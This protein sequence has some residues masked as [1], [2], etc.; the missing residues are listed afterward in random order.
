MSYKIE[1]INM[2]LKKT[3]NVLS[4]SVHKSCEILFLYETRS[5]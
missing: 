4:P 1:T 2:N 3:R 5:R